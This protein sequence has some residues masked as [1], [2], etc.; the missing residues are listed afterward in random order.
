M[1]ALA[2]AAVLFALSGCTSEEAGIEVT[3]DV[4]PSNPAALAAD[5][6]RTVV[7]EHGSLALGSVELVLCNDV[8]SVHGND[9]HPSETGLQLQHTEGS[10]TLLGVP[11][12]L[13]LDAANE[14]T[15]LG[16][17]QPPPGR[18]CAVRQHFQPADDDALGLVDRSDV[19]STLVA[20][21]SVGGAAFE[22]RTSGTLDVETTL[23]PPLE[24]SLDGTRAAS[25]EVTLDA[26]SNW[27]S[28]VSFAAGQETADADLALAN[29]HHAVGVRLRP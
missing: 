18:Y 2:C 26:A 21:G 1:R 16:A 12:L 10:A 17:V 20:R 27:L 11:A 4:A 24:L 29:L 15:T 5:D 14:R 3:F 25:L 13:S 7:L 22:L 28:G 19:G 23:E 8:G 9:S 6:G